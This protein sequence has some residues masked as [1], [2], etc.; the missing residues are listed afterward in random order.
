MP[1]VIVVGVQWGDEGKGK[2]IDLL[3]SQADCVVRAQ[4]GNNAGHTVVIGKE[5]FKLSLIPSGIF[6][7]N[8]VCYIAAGTVIDPEV[9]S[10]E[11]E[12]LESRGIPLKERL[13]VSPGAHVILPYHK[14]IDQLLEKKKG[15]MALGTTGR[16]IGPCYADKA[17]RIGI[18]LGDWVISE[19]F[20]RIL[21]EVLPL[22]NDEL[23]RLYNASPLD[24]T[25]LLREASL[26]AKKLV[27]YIRQFEPELHLA[28]ERNDKILFEGAQGTFLDN[29]YGTYPF[30][31]SSNTI[32]GGICVGAGVGP[33][34]IEH[35]LGVLKAY[36]TRVGNG[37]LPTEIYEEET[38]LDHREAREYGTTTGRKRRVGWFD[39]VIARTGV[40]LNGIQSLALTKLDILDHVEAL[41][42][43]TAY[44]LDGKTIK[45]PPPLSED[46]LRVKP[47]YETLPGWRSATKDIRDPSE[48]PSAARAYLKRIEQLC[49]VPITILSVGP[50]RESTLVFKHPFGEER[51]LDE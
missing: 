12:M 9:L 34:A 24:F 43:C 35:V 31:T 4:G 16:G 14:Q 6:N 11:I 15:K 41:K 18:L 39:A 8:T 26:F 17:N 37:P 50:E 28:I 48:L 46:L 25:E 3:A 23:V 36:T 13:W 42:I 49:G 21:G 19:R 30:V 47:I 40:R 7:P 32:A 38:F 10:N 1:A 20:S 33:S 27:P 44:Q 5:E 22:K 45:Y 29:T 2:I 51:G